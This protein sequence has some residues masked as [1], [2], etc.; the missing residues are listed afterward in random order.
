MSRDPLVAS[1]Y[2]K[3][4]LHTVQKSG[5]ALRAALDEAYQL[6]R[7]IESESRLRVFLEGP[8]FR[9]EDKIRLIKNVFQGR[10]SDL[11]LQFLLLLLRRNR[12]V[13]LFE[14]FEE[15][16]YLVEHEEGLTMGV[17]TTAVPASGDEIDRLRFQLEAATGLK[18]D[19]RVK[20]DPRLIGG[21]KVQYKDVL[22]DSTIQTYLG[23]LRQRL[24]RTRLAS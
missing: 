10:L 8:Q 17:V 3:A 4:L 19:L 23:D 22:M 20:V 18:F 12:I 5:V 11:F 15:F 2:A 1:N 24:M 14:I 21:V 16:E 6:R 7:L 9:D 13:N